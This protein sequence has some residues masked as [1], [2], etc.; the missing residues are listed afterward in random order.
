MNVSIFPRFRFGRKST[1]SAKNILTF[2]ILHA[3]IG[4]CFIQREAFMQTE[5]VFLVS[6][7]RY[8][9]RAGTPATIV[10]VEEVTPPGSPPRFCYKVRFED[11]KEDFVPMNETEHYKIV[12][13]ADVRAGKIP[14]VTH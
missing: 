12:S 3:I 14:E 8:G 6:I 4:F 7:H 9:F 5:Q 2:Y 1:S 10:G 13:V 11:G